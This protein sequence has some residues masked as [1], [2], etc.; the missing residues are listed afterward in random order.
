M[1]KLECDYLI[2][3][4]GIIGLNIARELRF[5]YPKSKIII[6]EKENDVARHSSG[7]NSGV[8]HAGFYYTLN[9]LKA[10]FTKEGN[11]LLTEYCQNKN[12][13]INQCE[14]IVVAKNEEELI[15]LNELY[16]RGIKNGVD[17]KLI[18]QEE[19]EK[20]IKNV[21]TYKKALYSPTTSTVDP[22]EVCNSLKNDLIE[23][24][25]DFL[26]NECFIK[27]LK[28]NEIQTT[29]KIIKAKK[30]INSAGLYADKIAK[31][32]GFSKNYTILPFKGIYLKY[33]NNDKPIDI[34]IYPVPNLKNPFLGVHYTITVDNTIKIGPTAIPAFWRENYS[35]F[36]N[37]NLN[38][39][40]EILK[41][42][43]KLFFTNAF[44]F[45]TLA[46]DE[47]KKYNKN[48]FINLALQMVKSIS[49]DGFNEWSKPGIRAQLLDTRT[50]ELVQ[51]FVVEGDNKSIHV[52]NA[53]SPAF[54]CSMPFSKWIVENYIITKGESSEN[55]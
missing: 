3:G 39:F 15:S 36:D 55:H 22:I 8:I 26:F 52:L 41:Y 50:L 31:Q 51:D 14:K 47:I 43:I 48:Y 42:E 16:S 23:E 32:F 1:D 27:K 12:L 28:N 9:S 37:F 54:T 40:I 2:I 29:N 6:I 35:G 46:F 5:Y 24:K 17:I 25:V 19:L 49:K 34:N 53:V 10:K 11:R 45:R 33:T 7:R 13:K 44:N 38:E 21:K 30:I 4:A 18:S 20:K